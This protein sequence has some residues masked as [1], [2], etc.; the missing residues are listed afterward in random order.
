MLIIEEL[1][2]CLL[3][4]AFVYTKVVAAGS[5]KPVVAE[6]FFD[7]ANW[8]TVEQQVRGHSVPQ[9]VRR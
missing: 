7:V 5:L 4:L 1:A 6:N 8:T 2:V 9:N 3:C